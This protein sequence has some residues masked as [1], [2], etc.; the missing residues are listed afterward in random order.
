[1]YTH[2]YIHIYDKSVFSIFWVQCEGDKNQLLLEITQKH[3]FKY[4]RKK[5]RWHFR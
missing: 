4:F 3:I 1:M 2:M 5:Y